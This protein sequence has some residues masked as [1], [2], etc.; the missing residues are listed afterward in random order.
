MPKPVRRAP[1][2]EPLRLP[3]LR[4]LEVLSRGGAPTREMVRDEC[5]FSP[6]SGTLTTALNGIRAG[7]SSGRAH[8]G[9][10]R[11]GLV[12]DLELDV[13]GRKERCLVLTDAG[14]AALAADPRAFARK[15]KRDRAASTNHRFAAAREDALLARE[16]GRES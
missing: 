12:E 16:A 11:L 9:L 14:R 3:Q 10:I 13:E 5:G 15:P 7:S 4:V 2:A 1:P 8:A 6:I